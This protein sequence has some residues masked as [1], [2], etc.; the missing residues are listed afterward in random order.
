LARGLS[1]LGAAQTTEN[2]LRATASKAK[3]GRVIF[4]SDGTAMQ[5]PAFAAPTRINSSN[6]TFDMQNPFN[7]ATG[8]SG[9]GLTASGRALTASGRALTAS[10]RGLTAGAG[11]A[12]AG[13]IDP[14]RAAAIASYMGG[15]ARMTGK[16]GTDGDGGASSTSLAATLRTATAAAKFKRPLLNKRSGGADVAAAPPRPTTFYA[17]GGADK[18]GVSPQLATGRSTRVLASSRRLSA[19]AGAASGSEA[20]GTVVCVRRPLPACR[21]P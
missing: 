20:G 5:D 13:V 16:A 10:G 1:S 17:V 11:G 19:G 6:G 18:R 12:P 3:S 14:L 15:A 21:K 7:L 2:A 8:A 9:R 4:K